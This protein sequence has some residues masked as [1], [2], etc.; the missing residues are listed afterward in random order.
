MWSGASNLLIQISEINPVFS[1]VEDKWAET[2][3]LQSE[4]DWLRWESLWLNQ[5]VEHLEESR[6]EF[7]WFVIK[8][9]SCTC[10]SSLW[11]WIGG[12]LN[13]WINCFANDSLNLFWSAELHTKSSRNMNRCYTQASVIYIW[14]KSQVSGWCW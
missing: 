9:K 8:N 4:R 12:I 11:L 3:A 10:R 1:L 7:V 13:V 14:L 6:A 5:R 2:R